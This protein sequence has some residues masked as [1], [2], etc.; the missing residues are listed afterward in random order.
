[1]SQARS[2]CT[3]L[4]RT[5]SPKRWASVSSVRLPA[6]H[7]AP[8]EPTPITVRNRFAGL[9]V[10][11]PV[12]YD[13]DDDEPDC[14]PLQPGITEN[15]H[16]SNVV[17]DKEHDLLRVVGKINDRCATML[18]DSGST[19]DLITKALARQHQ[20]PTKSSSEVLNASLANGTSC[21][22]SGATETLNIV[23]ADFSDQQAFRVFPL[24]MYDV[25]LGKPWLTR[26]N[27][28]VN[29]RT[30]QVTLEWKANRNR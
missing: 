15:V 30:N 19:H 1:M 3:E 20:L 28:D 7:G 16:L 26:Y 14:D 2:H 27:L 22:I 10:E 18:I 21:R 8:S 6:R 5:R 25:I 9:V 11:E 4:P 29:F 23:V 13:I 12:Y 24:A 17:V